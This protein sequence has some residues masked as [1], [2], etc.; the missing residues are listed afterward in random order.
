MSAST[1]TI[2]GDTS[3]LDSDSTETYS[4][5]RGLHC[6]EPGHSL[7]LT[8]WSGSGRHRLYVNAPDGRHVG[9]ADLDTGERSLAI[10]ELGP[11]FDRAVG[12]ASADDRAASYVPR[13]ALA[14]QLQQRDAAASS[15]P[16]LRVP[17]EPNVQPPPAREPR[18]AAPR[19]AA[20]PQSPRPASTALP[21][22]P[23]AASPAPALVPQAEWAA[24]VGPPFVADLAANH[25]GQSLQSQIDAAHRDGQRP[26]IVRRVLLGK[27]AY[28]SWELGAIGEQLVA[29]ELDRLVSRDRRWVYL[30]SIPVG[31][32]DSDI[33]HL[34]IGPGGVFTLNAKHHRDARIWVGGNTVIVNGVRQPYV[35]NSRFEAQRAGRL[36]SAATRISVSARGLVVPVGA[37]KFTVKQQPADVDVVTR[38]GLVQYL[39]RQPTI[40]DPAAI[41]HVLGFA[42]L[43]STWRR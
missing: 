9:W 5:R 38:S 12:E 33:D 13:R 30:N 20:A 34:V 1:L 37:A 29:R 16:T 43:S 15:I 41:E 7:V 14:D 28:S 23:V 26:T 22:H 8:R 19:P 18:P 39:I 2:P 24:P 36:L 40:L 32:N 25:P 4:A 6:E 42:R 27:N 31:T 10:P 21:I 11:S 35:R 17:L 3:A